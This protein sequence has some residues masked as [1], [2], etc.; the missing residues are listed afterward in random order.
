M[1]KPLRTMQPT[2]KDLAEW[3]IANRRGK[4]FEGW[5]MEQVAVAFIQAFENRE[6][7]YATD[8]NG[9]LIGVCICK[10]ADEYAVMH[11]DN[12]LVKRGARG[13]LRRFVEVFRSWYPGWDL[14]GYR[15]ENLKRFANGQTKVLCDKIEGCIL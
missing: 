8:E 14:Q 12:L 15:H 1:T 13:V 4:V 7:L 9:Y 5:T 3:V 2:I 10:R 6:A 11:V